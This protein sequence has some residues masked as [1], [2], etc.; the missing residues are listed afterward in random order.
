MKNASSSQHLL[1]V[2][3]EHLL[4]LQKSSKILL[5]VSLRV[6]LGFYTKA[7]LLFLGLSSL[8]SAASPFTD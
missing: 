6:E 3:G 7:A 8:V 5:S 1:F 4:V 2:P